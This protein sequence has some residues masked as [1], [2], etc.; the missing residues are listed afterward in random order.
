MTFVPHRNLHIGLHGLLRG[1]L[2]YFPLLYNKV[3]VTPARTFSI[4]YSSV[5]SHF[6]LATST[7]SK[8]MLRQFASSK[9]VLKG[10]IILDSSASS[11]TDETNLTYGLLLSNKNIPRSRVVRYV[12]TTLEINLQYSNYLYLF[13]LGI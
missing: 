6:S 10:D 3:S 8:E 12:H 2:Y 1:Y 9:C 4:T 13:I 11:L 5:F 7:I